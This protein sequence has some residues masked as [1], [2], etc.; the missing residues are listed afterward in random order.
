MRIII[1]IT[2]IIFTSCTESKPRVEKENIATLD[3]LVTNITKAD[4]IKTDTIKRQIEYDHFL[5][6]DEFR[7]YY[8]RI[9]QPVSF[10]KNSPV[11]TQPDT[12][13]QVIDSL[14]FNT[15]LVPISD[16]NVDEWI[17]FQYGNQ[18]AYIRSS[19]VA[20]YSFSSQS[21]KMKYFISGSIIYKYDITQNVFIDTFQLVGFT[22]HY[23]R[24]LNSLRWKNV[25]LLLL[26][27]H[28]GNC[29]GCSDVGIY[30][31]D[32][33]GKLD[34]MFKTYQSNSDL[35]GEEYSTNVSL[36]QDPQLDNIIYREYDYGE[37]FDMNNEPI[38]DKN[39]ARKMGVIKDI[40][41]HYKWDGFRAV[42]QK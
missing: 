4:T 34:I 9:V 36:P 37:L 11:Y 25:D 39:G 7:V 15:S 28:H 20:L 41:K 19:D 16:T 30:L 40:E 24:Q 12:S 35:E 33:N 17:G 42:E 1:A 23:A 10:S 5:K 22:P 3:T 26:L 13:S 8:K 27:E 2:I 6:L 31:V 38:L 21:K 29:C 32:A 14:K 18:N